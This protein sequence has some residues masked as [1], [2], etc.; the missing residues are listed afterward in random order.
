MDPAHDVPTLQSFVELRS[1]RAA[2]RSVR[3]WVECPHHQLVIAGPSGAGKT[4][5]ARAAVAAL[6]SGDRRWTAKVLASE[7]YFCLRQGRV[8]EDFFASLHSAEALVVEHVEDLLPHP[9]ILLLKRIVERRSAACRRVLLT[10]TTR[11]DGL[12]PYLTRP[13][14]RELAGVLPSVRCVRLPLPRPTER[15]Q[16]A[17]RLAEQRSLETC[18]SLQ[19]RWSPARTA[20]EMIAVMTKRRAMTELSS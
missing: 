6:G 4:H 20:A 7:H 16:L 11:T 18:G 5:L 1:N 12:H 17:R 15:A 3:T 2:L 19:Q 10:I 13:P 8:E 14:L 9:Q